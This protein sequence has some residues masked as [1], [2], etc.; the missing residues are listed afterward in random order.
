MAAG[1]SRLVAAMIRTSQA[2]VLV[3]PTRTNSRSCNTRSSLTCVAAEI[4]PISSRNSVPPSASS[5]RPILR[6]TAPVNAPFS[7]PKSSLSSSVSASA[8]QLI[9]MKVRSWRSEREWMCRAVSSFP[10]PVS[11]SSNTVALLLATRAHSFCTLFS[12]ALDPIMPESRVAKDSR[13]PAF[14]RLSCWCRRA[15]LTPVAASSANRRSTSTSPSEN[16]PSRRLITSTTPTT[17]S[18]NSMGAASNSRVT[19]VLC[20]SKPPKNSGSLATSRTTCTLRCITAR[21]A[22]PSFASNSWPISSAPT[23]PLAAAKTSFSRRRSRVS[24]LLASA[25][26]IRAADRAMASSTSSGSSEEFTVARTPTSSR[27]ADRLN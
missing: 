6:A 25:S 8:A 22:M 13:R 14:S 12:A 19:N 5:N 4:S 18:R 21:P 24:T 15:L 27:H 17:S 26:M 9:P 1:R 10:V 2:T 20:S 3:P 7:C 23:G 16:S 11:P